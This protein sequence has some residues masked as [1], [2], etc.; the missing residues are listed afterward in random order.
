MMSRQDNIRFGTFLDAVPGWRGTS[1]AKRLLFP[2][3]MDAMDVNP[4][5]TQNPGY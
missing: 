2:I 3:P 1:E 5:L 4:G